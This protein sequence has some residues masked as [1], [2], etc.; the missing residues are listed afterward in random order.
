MWARESQAGARL[1]LRAGSCGARC[2]TVSRRVGV[3][4]GALSREEGYK[5]SPSKGPFQ[6]EY[7][8]GCAERAGQV[9]DSAR[10]GS[11]G[12]AFPGCWSRKGLGPRPGSCPGVVNSPPSPYSGVPGL[13]PPRQCASCQADCKEERKGCRNQDSE[14]EEGLTRSKC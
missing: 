5:C 1:V 7:R 12:E 6:S 9:G 8:A 4:G 3:G 10:P 13:R 14:G 11:S 2:S